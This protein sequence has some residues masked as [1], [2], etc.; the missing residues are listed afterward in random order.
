MKAFV[1]FAAGVALIA[2]WHYD[3]TRHPRDRSLASRP[4]SAVETTR[5][6]KIA[7]R[8]AEG[9]LE[10][11]RSEPGFA[12]SRTHA[13]AAARAVARLRR[14]FADD[15]QSLGP[16]ER[17]LGAFA[18]LSQRIADGLDRQADALRRRDTARVSEVTRELKSLASRERSLQRQLGLHSCVSLAGPPLFA[19]AQTGWNPGVDIFVQPGLLYP[20]HELP[21]A[22]AYA[23]NT[24]PPHLETLVH[25]R[26]LT[27]PAAEVTRFGLRRAPFR[28]VLN[29]SAP[30][31]GDFNVGVW[32]GRGG[33]RR[34]H[35][36]IILR[37]WRKR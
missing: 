29:C 21:A 16:D 37:V 5:G 17:M 8:N 4:L 32:A 19:R 28:G 24:K 13:I 7:C 3:R 18:H 11:L 36:T 31:S 12:I 1:L 23:V 35:A 6:L 34:I 2:Y 10:L 14:E 22:Y 27:G 30:C 26:G 15:V 33:T 20:P 25:V 9:E